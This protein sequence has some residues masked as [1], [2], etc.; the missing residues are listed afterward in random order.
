LK[1]KKKKE[2]IRQYRKIEINGVGDT[3]E[4]D[5]IWKIEEASVE[6]CRNACSFCCCELFNKQR[7]V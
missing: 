5:E 7:A 1:T 4:D 3:S 6:E 2:H